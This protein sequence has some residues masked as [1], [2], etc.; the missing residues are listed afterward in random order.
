MGMKLTPA[1]RGARRVWQKWR[2]GASLDQPA[3]QRPKPE[4]EQSEQ[5]Q[6]WPEEESEQPAEHWPEEES[7][8]PAQQPNQWPESDTE[9]EER[10]AKKTKP[11]RHRR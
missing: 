4:E 2:D 11:Q 9:E 3:A 10:P 7:E 6:H 8:Q 5:P 1:G